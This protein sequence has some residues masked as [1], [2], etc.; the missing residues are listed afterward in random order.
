MRKSISADRRLIAV[1]ICILL[2][3]LSL[4][5]FLNTIQTAQ[6]ATP[7]APGTPI[8]GAPGVTETTGQIMSRQAEIDKGPKRTPPER[9]E[10]DAD[11]LLDRGPN[12]R[13]T[14]RLQGGLASK[15]IGGQTLPQWQHELTGSGRIWYCPDVDARVIWVTKVSLNHPKETT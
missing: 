13:R 11:L 10:F 5:G 4:A 6:A 15:Q 14:H 2:V 12:P 3:T 8:T 9:P 7:G 1:L